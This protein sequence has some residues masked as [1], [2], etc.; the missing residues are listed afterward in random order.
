MKVNPGS[1]VIFLCSLFSVSA[2]GADPVVAVKG[3]PPSETA[4]AGNV[5]VFTVEL[6]IREPFHINS[7]KPL[8]EYLIPTSL[9][10]EPE[11]EVEFGNILFPVAEIKEFSFTDSPMAVYEGTV[12]IPVEVTPGAGLSGKDVV[13]KG[14]VHYQACDNSTCLPPTRESFTVTLSIGGSSGIQTGA[15][16]AASASGPTDDGIDRTGSV[17]PANESLPVYVLLVFLSGLALNLTPCVYPM[18]PITITYFG[19]QA[20]GKKGSLLAHS[21][22]YV[23]GMAV[24]Y[25]VLGVVA[26]LTGGLLGAALRYP[27]VLIG[28]ALVMVF[29]ALSMFDVYELRMP[30]F[31]NRLAGGSRKGYTGTFLMGLTVGIVAAPCIGPFVFG[32]LT[33]VGNR[34]NAV[35]GFLLFFVLALGLGIPLLILAIFSGSIQHLPRSGDWMVWVRKVFGFILLAMAVFFLRTL[36]PNPLI[37]PLTLALISVLAGVYLAWITPVATTGKGFVWFRNIVGIGFFSVALMVTVTGLQSYIKTVFE[38]EIG[39]TSLDSELRGTGGIEWNSFSEQLL[40]EASKESKPV[41][42]DFYADWCAP[43]KELD[44][45]TFTAPEVV[46]LSRRFVMLKVDLTVV[47]DPIVEDLREKYSILGVPTLIFLRPD[48][49]EIDNLR[50]MKFE[51]ADVFLPKMEEA[52]RSV[53]GAG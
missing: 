17:D 41:L 29:L 21:G 1:I 9:E 2:W 46:E 20:Q 30:S 45:H 3:I 7:N 49:S 14:S 38:D 19:G 31:I 18:I 32:L 6:D 10:F 4:I 39:N 12:K 26:A 28:I 35:L 16:K 15:P 22:L 8:E 48:L 13:L 27:P 53:T 5:A 33:Y 44:K 40:D 11:P 52:Y 42:I 23:V 34:G 25:S 36:F 47:G 51:P 50:V 43:C 24:T 37:F